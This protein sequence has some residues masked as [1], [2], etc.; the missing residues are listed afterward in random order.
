M[1]AQERQLGVDRPFVRVQERRV[2]PAG[3]PH[4]LRAGRPPRRA[5][6]RR[7]RRGE[8]GDGAGRAA[9][10]RQQ[11]RTTEEAAG[12]V[13]EVPAEQAQQGEWLLVV[14]RDRRR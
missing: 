12:R 11:G 10:W 1:S 3:Q 6:G 13:E 9:E 5:H 14:R 7:V 2:V 4:Q 8:D